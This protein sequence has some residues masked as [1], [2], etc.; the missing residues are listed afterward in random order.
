MGDICPALTESR[1][2]RWNFLEQGIYSTTAP[3][4]PG[5]LTGTCEGAPGYIGVSGSKREDRKC[6]V[7]SFPGAGARRRGLLRAWAWTCFDVDGVMRLGI[8]GSVRWD[9]IQDAI[10]CYERK[11]TRVAYGKQHHLKIRGMPCFDV[12]TKLGTAMKVCMGRP[13]KRL[14]LGRP[15]RNST[16]SSDKAAID[17]YEK[18]SD[19]KIVLLAQL[20]SEKTP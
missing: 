17:A 15:S 7:T 19:L 13:V 8:T 16:A 10:V 11:V 6:T 2:D 4:H 14:V 18:W 12:N 1:P 20:F 5:V 9:S 3:L